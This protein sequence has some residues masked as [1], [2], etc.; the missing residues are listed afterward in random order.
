VRT[1]SVIGAMST[2]PRSLS[3]SS[4]TVVFTWQESARHTFFTSDAKE[5]QTEKFTSSNRDIAYC[6]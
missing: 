6:A 5:I 2:D 4:R 1:A 3:S